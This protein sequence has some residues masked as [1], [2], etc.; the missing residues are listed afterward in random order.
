[1]DHSRL[2][3]KIFVIDHQLSQQSHSWSRVIKHDLESCGLASVWSNF[4]ADRI[5]DSNLTSY[6]QNTMMP[7]VCETYSTDITSMSRLNNYRSS[8]YHFSPCVYIANILSRKHQSYFAKLRM[9][10]L[11]WR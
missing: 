1:M 4:N 9:G 11:D 10:T 6:L 7:D 2:T 5:C 3:R 8:Q